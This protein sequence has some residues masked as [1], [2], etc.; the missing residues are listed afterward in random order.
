MLRE[1]FC[2]LSARAFVIAWDVTSVIAPAINDCWLLPVLRELF[3]ESSMQSLEQKMGWSCWEAA[4]ATGLATDEEI[5]H[6]LAART[7]FRI[8]T[9]LIVSSD[10]RDKVTERLA[11]KYG[12]LPL[13]ISETTLD[14]A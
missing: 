10:A 8:A 2:P 14:I 7:H 9:D 4:V 6:A 11:R 1:L 3:G 5:L 12:I 13:S